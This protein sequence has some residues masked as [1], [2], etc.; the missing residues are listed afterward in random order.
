M[1]KTEQWLPLSL[2]IKSKLFT[3]A[4]KTLQDLAFVT[5]DPF[6]LCS[7][8]R[9]AVLL[10]APETHTQCYYFKGTWSPFCLECASIMN[11]HDLFF[12]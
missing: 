9:H 1:L 4:H 2:L 8:L 3:M 7:S 6:S 5:L 12:I 11:F 10:T